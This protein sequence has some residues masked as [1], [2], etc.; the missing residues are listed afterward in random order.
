MNEAS[1]R[2]LCM[3]FAEALRDCR[4]LYR[5]AAEAWL[6]HEGERGSLPAEQR[7]ARMEELHQ[8][9]LIKV[10]A[11]VTQADR[12][13]T[14]QEAELAAILVE[15]LWQRRLSGEELAQAAEH[16]ITQGHRIRWYPLLRPFDVVPAMRD[17]VDRLET[18]VLRVANLV[19][20]CDGT[21][22]A[23]EAA[24]LRSLQEE[25]ASHLRPLTLQ[26]S[27]EGDAPDAATASQVEQERVHDALARAAE[28]SGVAWP[29]GATGAGKVAPSAGGAGEPLRSPAERLEAA[30]REL[31]SLI[32]LAPVKQEI[33]TLINY[34]SHQ[35]QR[36]ALNLPT[37]P[38]SLHM[39][40]LG[41][42]GTGK[43]TV[44]RIF[45]QML[46]A[47][48]ILTKG[49]LVETDRSGLVAEYAGQTGPK[50]QRKI[51][52]ALGGVLFIDEAYSLAEAHGDDTYGR[53]ALQVLLKRMEDDRHHLAVILA[54]Y[55][56]PMQRLLRVNPGL[57]SRIAAHLH[58]PD[59]QP[60][61]LAQIFQVF[62]EK[63]H[64][65]LLAATRA[66]L[67]L[68]FHWLYAHRNE[69]FGNAR[70]VRNVFERAVRQL[71]N[72]VAGVAPV[73]VELLTVL[74]PEDIVLEG[75]PAEV[76]ARADDPRLALGV[77][78]PSCRF[79]GRM[80][81][82]RLGEQVQCKACGHTFTAEWGDVLA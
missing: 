28:P 2:E 75:V 60:R 5:E 64:Y 81:A 67:L 44:A 48:G 77:T 26:E 56:Q 34:L 57:A 6:A 62:C 63:N 25:L 69:R 53:E 39:L 29:A 33:A 27:S 47:L 1:F 36:R 51:D 4:A 13:W 35:Q 68:G 37:A 59:Y 50:T 41:N 65:R 80:R 12:R 70:L 23:A 32:G 17:E 45:G 61:E 79:Q 14:W 76:L 82:S 19:A 73:T 38:L 30:R 49:H 10:F 66:K 46:G 52:A 11:A 8:G 72:R 58:F 71:A 15:H 54:G 16:L 24:Q 31:E 22:S 21:V 18:V 55:P 74:Q 9:L 43:T 78:C 3:Q 20:K 40:F 42:P 7:L